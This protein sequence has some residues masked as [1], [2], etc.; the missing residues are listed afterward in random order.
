[1][2][3][4]YVKEQ[5]SMIQK[6]GERI[7]VTKAGKTLLEIPVIQTENM[8]LIGNVQISTQALHMLME[9][10]IDVSYF[11]YSGKYLGHTAAEASK[12]IFLRFQQY[13]FYLDEAKRLEMSKTIVRNKIQNQM[14]IIRRHRWEGS[15]HDWKS[16]LAQM[17]RYQQSLRDKATPNEVLGVEGICSNIYFGAFGNML[18]CDFQFHGRNRRPPR[19]PVN[20]MISLA[21]TFLTKEMCGALDAESFEPYLGF[22]HGIR[23]GRKSLALDMIEEFR[24]PM[25]DRLV[26]LLFNKNM[27]GRYDF[28]FPDDNSVVLNEDG[29]RK[30]CT[31]YERW[32]NGR[33]RMSGENSFRSR[34]REQ[35]AKLKR[36]I[37][38]G[39]E[40]KP[41]CWEERNV[42]D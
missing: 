27:I 1:M 33:N 20:V 7:V 3:V 30:F 29:F 28:E 14:A 31:E 13:Q 12:N 19:D 42:C 25:I 38:K 4:I 34:I 32:M 26:L 36:A 11:S 2:A 24:Q 17:K 10:G 16:D 5:G 41:Y 15:E 21:Y 6:S 18:K 9:K 22:L 23:Y 39:E 40:Y 37:G 35:V 8:A